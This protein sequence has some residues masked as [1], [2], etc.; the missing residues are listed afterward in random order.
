MALTSTTTTTSPTCP[1]CHSKDILTGSKLDDD[2]YWRCCKCGEMWNPKRLRTF[3]I[4]Q[5]PR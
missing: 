4:Y 3:R 2:A 1:F 5:A